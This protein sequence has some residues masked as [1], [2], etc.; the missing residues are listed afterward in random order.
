MKIALLLM[1]G[2]G[3]V[4][5]AMGTVNLQPQVGDGI[6]AGV[7]EQLRQ[8]RLVEV[9][10]RRATLHD[11]CEHLSS[12]LKKERHAGPITGFSSAPSHAMVTG[13]APSCITIQAILPSLWDV[14]TNI[15]RQANASLRF[16]KDLVLFEVSNILDCPPPDLGVGGTPGASRHGQACGVMQ[17]MVLEVTVRSAKQETSDSLP[18][19][20]SDLPI[21]VLVRVRPDPPSPVRRPVANTAQELAYRLSGGGVTWLDRV[22]WSDGDAPSIAVRLQREAGSAGLDDTQQPGRWVMFW[23]KEA[24]PDP[25]VGAWVPVVH[26]RDPAVELPAGVFR[27]SVTCRVQTQT[28]GVVSNITLSSECPFR[29]RQE[30]ST[31]IRRAEVWGSAYLHLREAKLGSVE[32]ERVKM[33]VKQMASGIAAGVNATVDHYLAVLALRIGMDD[34]AF[35]RASAFLKDGGDSPF[36]AWQLGILSRRLG[37]VNPLLDQE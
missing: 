24:P 17:Q 20:N 35:E 27:V 11:V 30:R 29:V 25:Y 8:D 3:M 19:L 33:H 14:V 22:V 15:A 9:D 21:D 1:V 12:R 32:Q 26:L 34:L 37:R 5:G 23:D 31:D 28:G 7:M 4:G 6:P 2:V 36:L 13:A 10:Y 18:V 16:E